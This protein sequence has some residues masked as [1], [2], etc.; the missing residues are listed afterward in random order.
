ML[1]IQSS[2]LLLTAVI[3]GLVIFVLRL[4]KFDAGALDIELLMYYILKASL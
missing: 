1:L 4:G 3:Q 2:G